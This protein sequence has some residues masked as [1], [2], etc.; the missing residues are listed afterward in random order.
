MPKRTEWVQTSSGPCRVEVDESNQLTNIDAFLVT[1]GD[2][3]RV[4]LK[5]QLSE[6]DKQR[7]LQALLYTALQGEASSLVWRRNSGV[8]PG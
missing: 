2:R 1:V 3:M 6:S 4:T 7:G 8:A 5:S